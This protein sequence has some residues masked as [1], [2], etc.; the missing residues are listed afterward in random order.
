MSE[1]N[2]VRNLTMVAERVRKTLPVKD[3]NEPQNKMW[4]IILEWM[5]ISLECTRKYICFAIDFCVSHSPKEASF[6]F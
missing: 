2:P 1:K 3:N 4:E 6:V 5:D